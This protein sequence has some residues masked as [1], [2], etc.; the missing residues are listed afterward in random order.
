MKKIT[1]ILPLALFILLSSFSFPKI[2]IPNFKKSDKVF[3]FGVATS[4][5]DSLAYFTAVQQIDSAKI[6]EGLL[7]H[8]TEYCYQLKGYFDSLKIPNRV[9]AVFFSSTKDGIDDQFKNVS[10]RLMKRG[11]YFQSIDPKNFRFKLERDTP[12]EI[13]AEKETKKAQ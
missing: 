12:E 3:A 7:K 9:C 10:S 5:T 6:L 11:A 8:R 1:A 4:F 2:K 13:E